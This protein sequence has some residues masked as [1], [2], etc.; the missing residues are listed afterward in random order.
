[1]LEGVEI[2]ILSR[3]C[4]MIFHRDHRLKAYV[5]PAL[6]T[7]IYILWLPVLKWRFTSFL[8]GLRALEI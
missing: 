3:V 6:L 1:M 5:A 4:L 7:I 8:M 2:V